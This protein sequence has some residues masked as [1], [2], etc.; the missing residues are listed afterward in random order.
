MGIAWL[1]AVTAACGNA[2][3]GTPP[4]SAAAIRP[5]HDQRPT[6]RAVALAAEIASDCAVAIPGAETTIDEVRDA[7]ALTITATTAEALAELRRQTADVQRSSATCPIVTYGT[8]IA[9]TPLPAGA[10][11]TL[12]PVDGSL[13]DLR[14]EVRRRYAAL[15]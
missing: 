7:V 8:R 12:S 11:V 1:I 4:L 5:L 15:P 3:A 14:S 2:P 10:R 13:D 6:A 9:V